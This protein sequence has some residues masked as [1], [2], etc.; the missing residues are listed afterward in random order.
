MTGIRMLADLRKNPGQVLT[1]ERALE[2]LRKEKFTQFL[3][4]CFRLPD[5]LPEHYKDHFLDAVI[6]DGEDS[7][8]SN[9][10]VLAPFLRL[11]YSQEKESSRVSQQ[12]GTTTV[13]A[14]Q[15]V[16][17]KHLKRLK[18]LSILPSGQYP[19]RD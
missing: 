6:W 12:S 8:G 10:P 11:V 16:R 13:G 18:N 2:A 4:R 14:F 5:D 3:D 9:D 17:I 19:Q 7:I 1:E 15:I